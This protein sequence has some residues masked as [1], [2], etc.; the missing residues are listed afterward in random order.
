MKRFAKDRVTLII[1]HRLSSLMHADQI[2]FIEDGRIVERGTHEELLA[3][4]GRYRAL[5]DLQVRP[6][7][8]ARRMREPA[9]MIDSRGRRTI[10]E[11]DATRRARRKAV[12]GSHRDEEEVFGKAYDPRIVRR[13]WAFVQPYRGRIVALGR[14]GAGVHADAAGDPADHPLRHRPRHGGG[15]LDRSVLTWA[16]AAFAVRH[17]HQLRRQLSAGKRGRQGRRERAVRHAP[18]HVR[19]SAARLAEPSWTRPR[20]A[21]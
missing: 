4:G 15:Q 7:D 6:D 1:A 18:R 11:E 14:G 21:G 3:L 16:I 13:I 19:P 9:L 12:V 2:L 20:S 17:P 8:D 5:Y 10:D